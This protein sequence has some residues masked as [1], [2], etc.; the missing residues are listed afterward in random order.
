MDSFARGLKCA[1]E[2]F[3]QGVMEK[4]V[5]VNLLIMIYILLI[6]LCAGSLF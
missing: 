1:V 6:L 4:C 5:K 2:L 3:N